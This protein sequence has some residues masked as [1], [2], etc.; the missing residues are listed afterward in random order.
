ML[1]LAFVQSLLSA[2][3]STPHLARPRR[4]ARARH[5]PAGVNL[6]LAQFGEPAL[7]HFMFLERPEGMELGAATASLAKRRPRPQSS[8]TYTSGAPG[9]GVSR[10]GVPD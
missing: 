5:Y 6:T 4:P 3:G 1:H 8:S 7:R 10:R 9:R 2:I